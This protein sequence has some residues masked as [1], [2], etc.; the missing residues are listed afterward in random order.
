MYKNNFLRSATFLFITL[1]ISTTGLL[2]EEKMEDIKFL[3]ADQA[4]E[5][6][7]KNKDNPQFI[8]LDVRTIDEYNS[9]HISNALNIDYKSSNFK[10]E[11][12]KLD[13]NKTY[14]TY[15]RSGRRSTEASDLMADM[16]FENI[17]M[18]DGGIMAWEK[19][20]LP[21]KN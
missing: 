18:I 10:D 12:G 7:E 5:L 9:G 15:C 8:I 11:V 6:I 20:N 4:D 2:A 17:Y 14:L 19:A 16:G 1:V 21:T 3:N 13:K